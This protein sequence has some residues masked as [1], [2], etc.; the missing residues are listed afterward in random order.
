MGPILISKMNLDL[1]FKKVARADPEFAI[2][3]YI[4]Y[5]HTSINYNIIHIDFDNHNSYFAIDAFLLF[6]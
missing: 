6:H 3:I 5:I 4:I 2:N 1:F